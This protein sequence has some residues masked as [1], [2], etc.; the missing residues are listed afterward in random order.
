MTSYQPYLCLNREGNTGTLKRELPMLEKRFGEGCLWVNRAGLQAALLCVIP[1][2]SVQSGPKL[3]GLDGERNSSARTDSVIA[4]DCIP[5]VARKQ[6]CGEDES[7]SDPALVRVAGRASSGGSVIDRRY[8][9]SAHLF[10]RQTCTSAETIIGIN[11]D[12]TIPGTRS[13]PSRRSF[14]VPEKDA[15]PGGNSVPYGGSRV[16][17]QDAGGSVVSACAPN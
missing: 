2:G 14:L 3:L 6:I 10:G 16:Y 17:G 5:S 4:A 9:L 1:P 8:R 7:V 15:R 11:R 13:G 12:V